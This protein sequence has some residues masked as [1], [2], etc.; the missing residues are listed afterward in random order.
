MESSKDTLP[1]RQQNVSLRKA[2]SHMVCGANAA[3][4]NQRKAV[5]LGWTLG[6]SCWRRRG[7]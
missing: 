4:P 5:A 7:C 1:Q 3:Q 6:Y 2:G